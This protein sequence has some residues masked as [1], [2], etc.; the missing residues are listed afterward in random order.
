[1]SV[2]AWME[3]W[4]G[5]AGWD[6]GG[7][8]DARR[9]GWG[10][11]CFFFF[12]N[13]TATTEIYTLSL[14]DAL[15]IWIPGPG[16]G[17][18]TA[19]RSRLGA[20]SRRPQSPSSSPAA[21]V[22][23]SPGC[24]I[25][26]SRRRLVW[27]S[28]RFC[29]RGL[30]RGRGLRLSR[31][32][33]RRSRLRMRMPRRRRRANS[34]WPEVRLARFNLERVIQTVHHFAHSIVLQLAANFSLRLIERN[35]TIAVHFV[36]VVPS[37]IVDHMGNFA[38]LQ[39]EDRGLCGRQAGAAHAGQIYRRRPDLHAGGVERFLLQFHEVFS[40]HG[41]RAQA[42]GQF[43]HRL[44]AFLS[45]C[46]FLGLLSF[47]RFLARLLTLLAFFLRLGFAL[48]GAR[49]KQPVYVQLLV[50]VGMFLVVLLNLFWRN[51]SRFLLSVAL[52]CVGQN[53]HG[54]KLDSLFKLRRLVQALLLG[55]IRHG[56]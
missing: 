45:L 55:F 48:F 6:G 18:Q 33:G 9:T 42:L 17:F 53:L 54:G 26:R 41:P 24:P 29:S 20:D 16:P 38:R 47:L 23:W 28:V 4:R 39:I 30:R 52:Q 50:G 7:S 14:H 46:F 34:A 19:T 5:R 22:A 51:L 37:R 49:H 25:H 43:A 13:D 31:R 44:F 27:P 8:W 36:N 35:L 32:C 10:C 56:D 12:F 1:M 40:G 3:A 11:L 21:A 2:E 15:P